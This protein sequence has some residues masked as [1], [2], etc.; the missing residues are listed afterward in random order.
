ML[1]AFAGLWWLWLFLCLASLLAVGI[2]YLLVTYG[3]A[4]D[5]A[6]IAYQASQIK[7]EDL[8]PNPLASTKDDWKNWG[9]KTGPIIRDEAVKRA[10]G[11]VVDRATR[12]IRKI[13]FGV[14]LLGFSAVNAVFFIFSGIIL[15]IQAVF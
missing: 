4:I 6:G 7:K 14:V 5:V 13:F 12:K 11:Y 3:T 10:R 1:E 2:N 9:N 8:P 15:T